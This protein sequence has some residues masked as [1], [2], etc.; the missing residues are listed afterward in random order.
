MPRRQVYLNE[1]GAMDRAVQMRLNRVIE[2]QQ[3]QRIGELQVRSVDLRFIASTRGD[4]DAKVTQKR[5]RLDLFWRLSAI[6]LII[7]PLRDR[8]ED[9]EPLAAYFLSVT[10]PATGRHLSREALDCLRSCVWSDNARQLRAVLVRASS[11]SPGP[12][13]TPEHLTIEALGKDQ[14]PHVSFESDPGLTPAE[15]AERHCM[16]RALR[17]RNITT[18]AV[19][20]GA[21]RRAF[22]S[23]LERY[24]IPC[25]EE[26]EE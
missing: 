6:T 3:V 9:I 18:A 23:K 13:I 26:P 25:P 7:P 24:R 2:R 20:L 21:T 16:V 19:S 17:D 4:L 5:F 10:R 11:L 1:V 8:P 22:V 14:I 15:I 12:E